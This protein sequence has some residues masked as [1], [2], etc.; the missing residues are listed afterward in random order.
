MGQHQASGQRTIDWLRIILRLGLRLRVAM[1]QYNKIMNW[2]GKSVIKCRQF[3]HCSP[4]SQSRCWRWT[5]RL[6]TW[7][8]R[9]LGQWCPVWRTPSAG[10]PLSSCSLCSTTCWP[11]AAPAPTNWS[12]RWAF[13]LTGPGLSHSGW[14]C[15]CSTYYGVVPWQSRCSSSRNCT[16]SRTSSWS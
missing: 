5:S 8:A 12:I 15:D 7:R 2:Q 10:S 9:G 14:P 4:S 16:H 3:P 1:M 13:L 6:R 11:S